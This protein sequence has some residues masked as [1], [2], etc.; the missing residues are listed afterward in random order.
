MGG[1]STIRHRLCAL[2]PS[3]QGGNRAGRPMKRDGYVKDHPEVVK[4][5]KLAGVSETLANHCC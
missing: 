1:H 5:R 2:H 3:N 4:L